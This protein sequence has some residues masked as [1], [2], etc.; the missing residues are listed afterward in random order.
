M[1][2]ENETGKICKLSASDN[3]V[4]N[5][6]SLDIEGLIAISLYQLCHLTHKLNL[7]KRL[8]FGNGSMGLYSLYWLYFFK[9][10]T[11]IFGPSLTLIYPCVVYVARSDPVHAFEPLFPPPLKLTTIVP[12]KTPRSVC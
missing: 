1:V 10:R 5:T 7:I 3:F 6:I 12:V 9:H 2:H 11:K 8:C 4:E